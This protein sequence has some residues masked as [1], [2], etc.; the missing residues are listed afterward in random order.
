MAHRR[1]AFLL[2]EL[3]VVAAL[4]SAAR[5]P[6]IWLTSTGEALRPIAWADRGGPS[7][8]QPR[9]RRAAPRRRVRR[10]LLE[11]P[12]TVRGINGPGASAGHPPG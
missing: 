1:R 2:A 9:P 10:Q 6:G 5:V 12:P 7:C 8:R 11:P 3:G 4:A